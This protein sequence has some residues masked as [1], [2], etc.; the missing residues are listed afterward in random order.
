MGELMSGR[1]PVGG[2]FSLSDANGHVRSLDEFRGRLVLLYFG[3]AQCPDVCPMDLASIGGALRLL[4]E[5]AG[6][7]Q[8]LFVTLDPARDTPPVLREYAAAFHPAWIALRG[9][10]A[11]TQRIARSYKV[12]YEKVADGKGGYSVDPAAFTFLL[13]RNGKYV[14][15][16]PPGTK[17]DRIATLLK[18]R[19]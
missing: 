1:S 2:P 11:D 5:R 17:P 6:E 8:P 4:G 7:V 15:F 13:D 3:Y 9:S 12:F 16:L 19:L 10:E 18:E 14:S